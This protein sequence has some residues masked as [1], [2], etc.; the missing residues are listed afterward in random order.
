MRT[1]VIVPTYNELANLRGII[2]RLHAAVDKA[3]R[4]TPRCTPARRA[5]SVLRHE[6]P[7]RRGCRVRPG[8]HRARHI[9]H[10]SDIGEGNALLHGQETVA[11]GDAGYQGIEKRPDAKADV[12][13]HVAMRP[14][15][16]R[17]LDKENEADA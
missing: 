1:L 5:T 14:G 12:T 6:G 7:H 4:A 3:K 10:V 2:A 8:A 13:W 15:K 9:R 17:A 16:R 11:F